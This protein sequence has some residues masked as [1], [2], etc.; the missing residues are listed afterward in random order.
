MAGFE[1]LA[2]IVEDP[3]M[4]AQAYTV[5]RNDGNSEWFEG[6]WQASIRRLPFFGVIFP[7]S[8]AQTLLVPEGE[9]VKVVMTFY[10]RQPF[11]LASMGGSSEHKSDTIEWDGY[12]WNVRNLDPY[13]HY[14]FNA[15]I[16]TR[17][18]E[19]S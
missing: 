4:G 19:L 16:A 10:S 17:E 1:D 5:I 13:T 3:D 11:A 7:P 8:Q 18:R 12:L 15:A 2:A 14:G 6:K 9:R